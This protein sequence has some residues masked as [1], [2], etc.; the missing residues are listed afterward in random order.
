LPESSVM[1]SSRISV[2]V[3][4]YNAGD[5]IDRCLEALAHQTIPRECYEII[6]VDDGSSDETCARVKAHAG[7]RL[8]AQPHAGPAVARN[9][10]V[11]HARGEIVLFTDS[12]CEPTQDWI[13]RMVTPF[14]DEQVVGVK[15][16]YLTRQREMVARFVQIEYEDKYDRMA[17][18]KYIDFVDTYSAGYRRA[19]FVTNGGFDPAFPAPSVEDQEFSFRL[20]RQGYK[21]VFVP[22]AVVYH[23]GH[24]RNLWSYCRRKF[25]IGYW[26]VVVHRRHPDRLLR[27][28]HTPQ[29]L[30]AQILLVGLGGFCFFGGFL[31]PPLNWVLGVLGLLF[32][33][34]TLPFVFKAWSKGPLAALISPGLLFVRGLALGMGFAA[35]LFAHLGSGGRIGELG[36]VRQVPHGREHFSHRGSSV[37]D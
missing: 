15:G 12:D 30:K 11:E 24:A 18:E 25:R 34:T 37:C 8:L 29:V 1:N 2:I 32:L 23:W 3:P 17:R 28:S 26:K 20:A 19:V 7:V 33:L 21:M 31:W 4:A 22:Q 27:D 36:N 14:R 16:T 13:E 35:G 6:V 5:T 10:G 9:L